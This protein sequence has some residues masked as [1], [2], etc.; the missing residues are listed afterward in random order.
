MVDF[1]TS[2]HGGPEWPGN[3]RE[4][5]QRSKITDGVG[6]WQVLGCG[7]EE[8]PQKQN[9][10]SMGERKHFP[11]FCVIMERR[12]DKFQFFYVGG[13]PQRIMGKPTH[14]GRDWKPNPHSFPAG[15]QT[16]VSEVERQKQKPLCQGPIWFDITLDLIEMTVSKNNVWNWCH[17][18]FIQGTLWRKF[19]TNYFKRHQ[20]SDHGGETFTSVA[21]MKYQTCITF[22]L[23]EN[24][25]LSIET[26]FLLCWPGPNFVQ[27]L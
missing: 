22:T 21:S 15:I 25:S 9:A 8:C 17:S 6:G 19:L 24:Y 14:L 5:G 20:V 26:V 3:R 16:G 10:N 18:I 4:V 23:F 2:K 7:M 13:K 1:K 12:K 11:S 27:L